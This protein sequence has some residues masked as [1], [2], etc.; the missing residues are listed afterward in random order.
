[1]ENERCLYE[2]LLSCF[3]KAVT[4][5]A[6]GLIPRR[7]FKGPVAMRCILAGMTEEQKMLWKRLTVQYPQVTGNMDYIFYETDGIRSIEEVA[8][9]VSC[10]TDADCLE[11]L[12]AFYEFF[13]ELRLIELT[14]AEE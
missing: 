14:K 13:R 5:E 7:L 9:C 12:Q 8:A 11:G 2:T 10:Q 4:E 3:K 1:M 6:H